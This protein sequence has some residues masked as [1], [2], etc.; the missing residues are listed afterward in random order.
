LPD[1]IR[2][3]R[4]SDLPGKNNSKIVLL[5]SRSGGSCCSYFGH[6]MFDF[7]R[8]PKVATIIFDHKATPA[9]RRQQDVEPKRCLG[10]VHA[11]PMRVISSQMEAAMSRYLATITGTLAL[12]CGALLLA[13]RAEAG[14]SAS[15]PSKNN[16]ASQLSASQ[17]AQANRQARRNDF[18]ITE[19][20]SSSP[21][22]P[23]H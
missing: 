20:S 13:D 5:F 4:K 11:R 6:A 14:A 15:A 21:R 10:N 3:V 2:G 23:Q 9:R 12:L 8:I 7:L 1:V 18:G 17:Q 22:N 16:R 19:F